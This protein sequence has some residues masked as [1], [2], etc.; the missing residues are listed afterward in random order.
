MKT[1]TFKFRNEE[2]R[3]LGVFVETSFLRD[4]ELFA[5]YSPLYANGFAEELHNK[6]LAVRAVMDTDVLTSKRKLITK[7]LHAAQDAMKLIAVDI[8]KYCKMANGKLTFDKDSLNLRALGKSLR[9]R[10][11]ES[12]I[13]HATRIQQLIAPDLAVLTETGFTA[14]RQ[15]EF[16]TLIETMEKLNNEQN[17]QLNERKNQ[18]AEKTNQLNEFW[19]MIR[20]LMETGQIIHRDNPPRR[21]EYSE[22]N[23]MT[24]VRL[25]ISKKPEEEVVPEPVA[26]TPEQTV[27]ESPPVAA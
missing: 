25:M 19:Q 18:V 23:L 21:D 20:D 22:K 27:K 8:H 1:K 5:A 26:E 14:E 17:D 11:N 15:A 4:K 10:N 2:L 7:S 9:G 12:C 16:N 6:L 3:A 13:R 24:R